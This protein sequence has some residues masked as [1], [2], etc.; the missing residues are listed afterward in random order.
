MVQRISLRL[1][2]ILIWE[3]FVGSQI[4]NVTADLLKVFQL[5]W[6]LER[7]YETIHAWLISF[8]RTH[9]IIDISLK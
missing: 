1:S 3:L 5:L 8:L 2:I 6:G 4:V 7:W 9:D